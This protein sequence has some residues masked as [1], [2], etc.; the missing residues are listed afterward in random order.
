MTTS[1]NALYNYQCI[2]ETKDK[3]ETMREMC[4]VKWMRADGNKQGNAFLT[5]SGREIRGE[6]GRDRDHCPAQ[7]T[8]TTSWKRKV[9]TSVDPYRANGPSHVSSKGGSFVSVQFKLCA[10]RN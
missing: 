9:I 3:F 4:N 8:D 5:T 1:Q 6:N 10:L 7:G 2:T